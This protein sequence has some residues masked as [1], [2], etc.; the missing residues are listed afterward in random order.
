MGYGRNVCCFVGWGMLDVDRS[1]KQGD[2][3][4]GLV[5]FREVK[6][7]FRGELFNCF[8]GVGRNFNCFIGCGKKRYLL[9]MGYE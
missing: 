9:L 6:R 3:V 2:L 7:D 1:R 5:I 8:G 4:V